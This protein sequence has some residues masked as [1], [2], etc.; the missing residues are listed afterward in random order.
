MTDSEAG[1]AWSDPLNR[2]PT[3]ASTEW[4]GTLQ[5]QLANWNWHEAEYHQGHHCDFTDDGN[6]YNRI[7]VALTALELDARPA[8]DGRKNKGYSVEHQ[9]SE[10]EYENGDQVPVNDQV[11]EIVLTS[12]TPGS[13][14]GATLAYIL[15]QHEA[16]LSDKRITD[17][18]SFRDYEA[19][20]PFQA[21]SQSLFRI[22]DVPEDVLRPGDMDTGSAIEN[23]DAEIEKRGG[24]E[25]RDSVIDGVGLGV[26]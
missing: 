25:R 9:D 22:E 2:V 15:L 18:T 14:I 16:V 1:K 10:E 26:N 5:E 20:P 13:P 12:T 23:E 3:T 11:R 7:G 8:T 17:I 24:V 4:Q 19:N 21:G 6:G